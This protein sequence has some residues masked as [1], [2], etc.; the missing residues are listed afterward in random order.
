MT[1]TDALRR[2]M[3]DQMATAG[4]LRTLPWMTAFTHVPRHLFVPPV[5]PPN[6]GQHRLDSGLYA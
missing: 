1:A 6:P 5:L 3:V 4:Y 2:A